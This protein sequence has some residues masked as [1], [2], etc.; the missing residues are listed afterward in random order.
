MT[1]ESGIKA[2]EVVHCAQIDHMNKT[3]NIPTDLESGIV[4]LMALR[5]S[6]QSEVLGKHL[7]KV[8]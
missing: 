8:I 6:N 4:N 7:M 2:R 3:D 1:C 5:C